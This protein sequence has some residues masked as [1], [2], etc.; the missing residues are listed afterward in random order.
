MKTPLL[1]AMIFILSFSLVHCATKNDSVVIAKKSTEVQNPNSNQH[2]ETFLIEMAD[3]RMMDSAEGKLAMKR[4]STSAIRKYGSIMVSDQKKILEKIQF[5]AHQKGVILPA[6]ISESKMEGLTD[7]KKLHGKK[8]DQKFSSMIAIDHKRDI[9]EFTT[10]STDDGFSSE[11][12]LFSAETLPLIESHL[13]KINQIS[14][15]GSK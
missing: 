5:V 14:L 6:A 4:G 11:V 1:C 8:F 13:E 15:K 7:L 3:A 2:D 10:A 9:K 12:K